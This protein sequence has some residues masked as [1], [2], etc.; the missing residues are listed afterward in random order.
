MYEEITHLKACG[1]SEADILRAATSSGAE[2][3]GMKGRLGTVR[4]GALAD[5]LVLEANPLE[6]ISAV[7]RAETVIVDGN[8]VYAR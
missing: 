2:V 7:G 5:L 8:I 4:K 6:D 1:M 3:I